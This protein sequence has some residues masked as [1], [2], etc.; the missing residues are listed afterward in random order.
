[1]SV[2]SLLCYRFEVSET[3]GNITLIAQRSTEAFGQVS[4]FVYAQ[5]LEAQLGLDYI[6]TPMV[7]TTQT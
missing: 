3:N 5:N 1:M 7:V 6:F 2:F 4:L